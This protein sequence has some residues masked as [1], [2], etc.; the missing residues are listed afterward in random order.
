M[1]SYSVT[2]TDPGSK[3]VIIIRVGIE[4]DPTLQFRMNILDDSIFRR[5]AETFR[6]IAA[7]MR[8]KMQ[9]R[10]GEMWENGEGFLPKD[11]QEAVKWYKKAAERGYPRAQGRMGFI[12]AKGQGVQMDIQE[13]LEWYRKAAE[14]GDPGSLEELGI[15]YAKGWG[16]TEDHGEAVKFFRQAAENGGPNQTGLFAFFIYTEQ[17]G[18]V[19][20]KYSEEALEW[21]TKDA[22]LGDRWSAINLGDI[23]RNGLGVPKDTQKALKWY[24]KAAEQ[25]KSEAASPLWVCEACV[26]LGEM[27]EKGDGVPKDF[28][29]SVKWYRKAA[30][31]GYSPAQLCLGVAY[32]RGAGVPKDLVTAYK[33]LNL[34]GAKGFEGASSVRDDLEKQMTPSQI[35]E[36]QRLSREFVPHKQKA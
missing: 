18:L 5:A 1:E 22:E 9:F 7:H 21:Y 26:K 6:K 27:H 32:W 11:F 19:I 13:A 10:L 25:K 23:H 12:Y 17:V 29:E 24:R 33:W 31:Q 28:H 34:A 30:E 14:Q 16:V 2:G 20:P 35:E 36:A 8:G 3:G 4:R 15:M